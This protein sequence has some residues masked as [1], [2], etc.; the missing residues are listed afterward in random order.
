MAL[1]HVFAV[2]DLPGRARLHHRYTGTKLRCRFLVRCRDLDI[3]VSGIGLR[4]SIA[5]YAMP[6]EFHVVVILF[7]LFVGELFR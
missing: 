1:F 2:I 6:R 4:A 3:D 5:I 7:H